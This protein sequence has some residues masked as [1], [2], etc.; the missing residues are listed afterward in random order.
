MNEWAV[1]RNIDGL[2]VVATT[3]CFLYY[4][5]KIKSLVRLRST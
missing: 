3:G 2:F 5:M 1:Y 4:S